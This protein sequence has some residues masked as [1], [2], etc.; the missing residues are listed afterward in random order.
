MKTISISDLKAHLSQQ[1]RSIKR[2]SRLLITERGRPIA[3]VGPAP[4]TTEQALARL[5]AA[6]VVRLGQRKLAA[7]FWDRP[8]PSDEDG[9]VLEAILEERREGR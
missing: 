7:D 5:Q 9:A 1:L 4:E 3:E 8:R 2:G 6:G